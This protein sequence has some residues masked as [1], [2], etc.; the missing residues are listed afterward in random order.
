M[1]PNHKH[2]IETFLKELY[3]LHTFKSLKCSVFF[4]IH[5]SVTSSPSNGGISSSSSHGQSALPFCSPI[6]S[7]RELW[8]E[9]D[10]ATSANTTSE[11]DAVV[12][13]LGL[14]M[15]TSVLASFVISSLVP[16]LLGD[17]NL[18]CLCCC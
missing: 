16:E 6:K 5:N 1:L 2:A 12:E 11:F 14:S 17:C 10:W 13:V 3:H 18:G 7:G 15:W 8:D 4:T 9:W